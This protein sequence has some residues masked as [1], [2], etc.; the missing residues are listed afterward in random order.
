METL[1]VYRLRLV[2]YGLPRMGQGYVG[3][4]SLHFSE[5]YRVQS[6]N[7]GSGHIDGR[8]DAGE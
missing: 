8:L 4:A 3:T 2:L 7:S 1:Q 5:G 6:L